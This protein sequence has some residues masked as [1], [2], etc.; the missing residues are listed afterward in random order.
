M[1][2]KVWMMSD[3]LKKHKNNA[4][5]E[6]FKTEGLKIKY[7]EKFEDPKSEDL[8]LKE[9]T[10][11]L[12]ESTNKR[13][14]IIT[15]ALEAE[16]L[17]MSL[18]YGDD[19]ASDR[20]SEL[21]KNANINIVT[22]QSPSPLNAGNEDIFLAK[23]KENL[24]EVRKAVNIIKLNQET[25]LAAKEI[26]ELSKETN[27]YSDTENKFNRLKFLSLE[28]PKP[29]PNQKNNEDEET[30]ENDKL[31]NYNV[32]RKVSLEYP[33]MEYKNIQENEEENIDDLRINK[34]KKL[35]N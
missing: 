27:N 23:S 18:L 16:R 3:F 21:E 10:K 6:I 20:T 31:N 11:Q 4:V 29:K 35:R 13:H 26:Q 8:F 25:S 1:E 34:S 9:S 19:V 2:E 32:E 12:Q 15:N 33:N 14:Q 30:I 24:N 5:K 28:P 22:M 17:K 7:P